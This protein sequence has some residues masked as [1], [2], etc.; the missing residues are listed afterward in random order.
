[1]PNTA[2]TSPLTKNSKARTTITKDDHKRLQSG[3]HLNRMDTIKLSQ[4]TVELLSKAEVHIFMD[5]E[6]Q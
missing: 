5:N 4:I 3:C 2:Y 1:M 6:L